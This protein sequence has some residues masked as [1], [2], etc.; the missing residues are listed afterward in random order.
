MFHVN[1][2]VDLKNFHN[3][4]ESCKL[5]CMRVKPYLGQNEDCSLGDSTSDSSEKLLHRGRGKVKI[6]GFGEG[7]VQCSHAHIFTKVFC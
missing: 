5:S 1:S 2:I 3:N 6:Y 7:G 4:C